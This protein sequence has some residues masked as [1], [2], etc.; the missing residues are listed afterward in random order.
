LPRLVALDGVRGVLALSVAF[1]HIN[2]WHHQF[3]AAW[4]RNF[5]PVLGFFFVL[6]GFLITLLYDHRLKDARSAAD[7]AIRRIGRQYPVHVFALGLLL[8]WELSRAIRA[9]VLGRTDITTFGD[10][11]TVAELIRSV[12][13]VHGWGFESFSSWNFPSW[14]LSTELIAYALF[15]IIV[16]NVKRLEMRIAAAVAIAVIGAVLF[17]HNTQFR[18]WF[19]SNVAWCLQGFFTGALLSWAWQ[20]WPIRSRALG[21]AVEIGSLAGCALMLMAGPT[22]FS[23]FLLWW[24]C[25]G[26]LI[27]AVASERGVVSSLL[28]SRPIVWV[29]EISLSIYLLHFPVM[30]AFNQFFTMLDRSGVLGRVLAP[31]PVR[32]GATIISFGPM[33]LMDL[34]TVVYLALA[35]A[36]GAV[37]YRFIE[38]PSRDFFGKLGTR[39][40]RGEI[41]WPKA[42]VRST[43]RS[44]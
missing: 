7:F 12:F 29:G 44:G 10:A 41:G 20:R 31:N 27:Y 8:C 39:V 42:A 23:M 18:Y 36:V 9:W 17:A 15:T 38:A 21:N 4:L 32:P 33:W 2:I 30:L 25:M 35:V 43:Q 1:F 14:T 28:A 26:G 40:K 22:G 24:L 6:S 5:H 37:V 16:V 13:L 19:G 3:E 34:L 11:W